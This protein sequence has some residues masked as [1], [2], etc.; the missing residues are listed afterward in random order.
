MSTVDTLLI[1]KQISA[2]FSDGFEQSGF[3]VGILFGLNNTSAL[4]ITMGLDLE[5]KNNTCEGHGRWLPLPEPCS[6][7]GFFLLKGRISFGK[8][9][10][11]FI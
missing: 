10:F 8:E 7:R 3:C 1:V 6:D 9:N 2:V 4:T 11:D 5:S